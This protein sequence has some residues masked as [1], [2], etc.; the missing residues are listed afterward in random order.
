MGL[1]PEDCNKLFKLGLGF[2]RVGTEK[3]KGTGV[4]LILC[5][6]LIEKHNGE[7]WVESNLGEGS[8]FSFMIPLSEKTMHGDFKHAE[9][10]TNG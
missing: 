7:I 5:K 6:E 4:G 1:S 9:L 2:K 10:R 8:N 3:E